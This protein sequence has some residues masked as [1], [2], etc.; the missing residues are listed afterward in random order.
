MSDPSVTLHPRIH[1]RPAPEGETLYRTHA[2]NSA[3]RIDSTRGE[4]QNGVGIRGNWYILY[5][6]AIGRRGW[7]I[8]HLE[9]DK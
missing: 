1:H 6:I 9:G 5:R 8:R 4:P 3:Q 7:I 2:G